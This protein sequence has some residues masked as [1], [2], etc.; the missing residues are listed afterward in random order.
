MNKKTQS[1]PLFNTTT[2]SLEMV[3]D[4]LQKASKFEEYGA[5]IHIDSQ[6]ALLQAKKADELSSKGI[7]LGP[8]HGVP[9]AIKDN[10]HV[11]GMPNTAGTNSLRKFVPLQNNPVVQSLIDAGAIIIG[12]TNMHELAFGITSNNYAFGAAANA[13]DI[14]LIAGGSS[15][16]SA[17][18]VALNIVPLTLGTDTGGS[19]RIPPALNG[20]VGFRPTMGRYDST[21]V[22]PISQT[23]DTIGP[24]ASNVSDIVLL[25]SIITGHQ[26]IIKPCSLKGLRLGIPRQYFY[27]NLAPNVAAAIDSTLTTLT[28]AGAVLIDVN[29]D[30]LEATNENV[31]FPIALYEVM[32]QLPEYLSAHNTGIELNDLIENISSPDVKGIFESQTAENKIPEDIYN[33]AIAF[34]RPKLQKIY[35]RTFTENN[36]SAL[37]LPATPISAQAIKTSNETVTLNGEQV[38]TFPT[39]VRNVDPTSNAGLPSLTIPIAQANELPIG[40]LIDGPQNSDRDLLAIGLAIEMCLIQTP[41]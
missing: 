33:K 21:H 20:T 26:Q 2:T 40:L 12:K 38:P 10:I 23:R 11:A 5:F 15:G 18:A 4:S 24:M 3:E 31:G 32:K 39:Y 41:M 27:E 1:S 7:S 9:I 17:S 25:D 14:S 36:I 19:V 16:G 29:M 35:Q 30:E 22:T 28:A 13:C 6:G 8:L 37:L 34:Y